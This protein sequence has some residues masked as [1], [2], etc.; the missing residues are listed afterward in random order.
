MLLKLFLS[1]AA[2]GGPD[3]ATR[4]QLSPVRCQPRQD[5]GHAQTWRNFSQVSQGWRIPVR[6]SVIALIGFE[7]T[8]AYGTCCLN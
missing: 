8:V 4:V 7:I 2:S 3:I 1:G 6:K 5:A